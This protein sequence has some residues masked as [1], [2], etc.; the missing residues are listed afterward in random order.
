MVRIIIGTLLDISKGSGRDMISI[1]SSQD[2]KNAG[3]TAQAQGLFFTGA[4]YKNIKWREEENSTNLLS[5][6]LS[7]R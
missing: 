4:S 7:L 2:R 1:L 5:F 3:K 6:L